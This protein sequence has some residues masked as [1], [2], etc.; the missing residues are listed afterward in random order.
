M[1]ITWQHGI[2]Q[3]ALGLPS[4][5]S[6]SASSVM[7]QHDTVLKL[8]GSHRFSE[9]TGMQLPAPRMVHLLWAA[10]CLVGILA[11]LESV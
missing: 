7:C 8:I 11:C 5:Q 1:P 2:E 9:N 4:P 3:N 10:P 6:L